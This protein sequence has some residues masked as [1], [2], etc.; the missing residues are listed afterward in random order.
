MSLL[1]KL[2]FLCLYDI[3]VHGSYKHPLYTYTYDVYSGII[4]FRH[5]YDYFI[6]HLNIVL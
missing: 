2:V 6:L 5:S 3:P 1:F 4:P